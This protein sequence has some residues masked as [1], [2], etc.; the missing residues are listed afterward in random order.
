M[1]ARVLKS[2]CGRETKKR[3]DNNSIAKDSH[4]CHF[5]EFPSSPAYAYLVIRILFD[6]HLYSSFVIRCY[7]SHF[8]C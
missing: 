7:F 2:V 6:P 4:Y 8:P 3:R 5:D 1:Q